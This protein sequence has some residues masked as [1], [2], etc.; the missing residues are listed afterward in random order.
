MSEDGS[1]R[2][3]HALC[4][5][6][7]E[8]S[9][10]AL[11]IETDSANRL[12]LCNAIIDRLSTAQ[13]RQF[14]SGQVLVH[15]EKPVLLEITPARY[16]QPE[17]LALKRRFPKAACSQGH[18]RTRFGSRTVAG[19]EIRGRSRCIGFRLPNGLA[20]R[21]LIPGFEEMSGRGALVRILTTSY[22]GA[23]DS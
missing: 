11:R 1:P 20:L 23:S 2:R 19:D 15:T 5:L 10:K 7:G 22:M 21:L 3:A 13:G 4:R 14:L 16:L 18:R 9:R 8:V 6:P 17:S 12:Q